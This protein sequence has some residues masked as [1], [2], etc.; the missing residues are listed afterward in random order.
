VIPPEADAEFVANME[1]V[2]KKFEKAYDQECPVVYMD[3]TPVR[4][5]GETRKPIPAIKEYPERIDYE[6]ERKG[7]ESIFM[8]AEP[9]SGLREVTSRPQLTRIDCAHEDDH[10]LDTRYDKT[11]QVILVCNNLNTHK[12]WVVYET[13]PANKGVSMREVSMLPTPPTR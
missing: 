13:F 8:F 9:M 12:K 4:L 5:V 2:L 7:T 10:L 1:E 3:E 6:H 11:S